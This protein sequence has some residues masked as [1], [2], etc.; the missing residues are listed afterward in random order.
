MDMKLQATYK[1]RLKHLKE[2]LGELQ[3]AHNHDSKHSRCL[4][5]ESHPHC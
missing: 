4:S 2:N 1:E 3:F 5:P